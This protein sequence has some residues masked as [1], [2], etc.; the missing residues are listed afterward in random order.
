MSTLENQDPQ[1]EIHMSLPSTVS[2]GDAGERGEKG[3]RVGRS[4]YLTLA[5]FTLTD[6]TSQQ[7]KMHHDKTK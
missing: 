6:D 2:V 4:S 1:C 5:T 3:G 7:E